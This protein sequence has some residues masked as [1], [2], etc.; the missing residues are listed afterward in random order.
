MSS[1][2]PG[3]SGFIKYQP[4]AAAPFHERLLLA[5]AHGTHWAIATPDLDVYVE[6]IM[7][8]VNLDETFASVAADGTMPRLL[9]GRNT[10]SFGDFADFIGAAGCRLVQE[11]LD[12]AHLQRFVLEPN[13]LLHDESLDAQTLALKTALEAGAWPV[14]LGDNFTVPAGGPAAGPPPPVLPLAGGGAALPAGVALAL[15]LQQWRATSGS[16]TNRE[17]SVSFLPLGQR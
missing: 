14:G 4:A 17:Q 13:R 12:A 10:Y 8:P 16:W 7:D 2:V 11:G 9:A 15:M 5:K 3:R 1:I 6:D